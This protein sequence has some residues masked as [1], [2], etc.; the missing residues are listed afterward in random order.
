MRSFSFANPLFLALLQGTLVP[1]PPAFFTYADTSRGGVETNLTYTPAVGVRNA[2]GND[3]WMGSG[4]GRFISLGIETTQFKLLIFRQP[5]GSDYEL[6][7]KDSSG[8]VVVRTTGSCYAATE[9]DSL[10]M[11]QS[12]ALPTGF[13][14]LE[15][16]T[17]NTGGGVLAIDAIAYAGAAKPLPY[18]KPNDPGTRHN[19]SGAG[20]SDLRVKDGVFFYGFSDG[21]C[22][23]TTQ[24][25]VTRLLA[26]APRPSSGGDISITITDAGGTVVLTDEININQ[27]PDGVSVVVYDS[28]PLPAS[29]Y[30][31]RYARRVDGSGLV[32][33]DCFFY[34]AA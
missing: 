9:E 19:L 27:N 16:N 17:L 22:E 14:S 5:N 23:Y 24:V 21:Y 28:G 4:A 11:W 34:Q 12:P 25:P 26:R 33:L 32:F 13:Y 3:W 18:V 2:H 10:E 30:T 20:N 6:L 29:I 7:I 1:P 31:I 15:V 8:E